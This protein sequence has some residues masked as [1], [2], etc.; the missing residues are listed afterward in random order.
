M[1]N[2]A[3]VAYGSRNDHSAAIKTDNTLWLWGYNNNGQ[4]GDN[5]VANKSS[6]VQIG[7]LAWSFVSTGRTFTSAV[8]SDG[9]LWAWGNNDQG[10]LGLNILTTAKRSS[11]VQ[12]GALT[13]WYEVSSGSAHTIAL[14]GVV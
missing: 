11:P 5:T 12:V 9:T 10:Q 8:K 7:L 3:K 14:L 1:T 4:L 6:P 2:W 13:N